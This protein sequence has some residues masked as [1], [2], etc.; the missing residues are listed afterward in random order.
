MDE[1][2]LWAPRP[3]SAP[4]PSRWGQFVGLTA[5]LAA[6]ALL[7]AA[8]WYGFVAGNTRPD[9]PSPGVGILRQMSPGY[10]PTAFGRTVLYDA[11][12]VIAIKD[13][14][15]LGVPLAENEPVVQQRVDG[16]VLPEA[17]ITQNP[18]D[19]GHCSYPLANGNALTV[20][21]HQTPF[22]AATD[23][24]FLQQAGY[25]AGA[26]LK[27]ENDLTLA[28]WHDTLSNAQKLNAWKPNLLVDV[29]I[30]TSKPWPAN[31]MDAATFAVKLVPLVTTAIATD[32]TGHAEHFYADPFSRL[33]NPCEVANFAAFDRAFPS[34]AGPP[35][36][37]RGTYH[38]TRSQS[39]ILM[40]CKR[41]NVVFNG[42]L[43]K[44]EHRELLVEFAVADNEQAARTE[45]ARLCDRSAHPEVVDAT[46]SVGPSRSCLVKNGTDWALWF[47]LDQVNLRVSTPGDGRTAEEA[48]EQIVPAALAMAEFGVNR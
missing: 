46:P 1:Q 34:H 26:T 4:P 41:T 30:G 5:G 25:R 42:S 10:S 28:Q 37:V 44:A 48:A 40:S 33:R 14:N 24:E 18:A 47:Q 15:G 3:R 38:P 39:S 16:S 36:I 23:L 22:T 32:S 17:A 21:V 13:L 6:T 29:S 27:T 43:N 9:R 2:H 8:C 20:T 7:A 31:G 35:S 12:S 11:C 45:N 19:A